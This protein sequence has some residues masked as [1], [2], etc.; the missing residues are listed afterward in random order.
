[1]PFQK[2]TDCLYAVEQRLTVVAQVS[3]LSLCCFVLTLLVDRNQP[4]FSAPPD[5]EEISG[6]TSDVNALPRADY[7]GGQPASNVHVRRLQEILL[8]YNAYETELGGARLVR[9]LFHG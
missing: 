6:L 3:K 1:M 4:L 2:V 5:E 7:A 9:N 8:T